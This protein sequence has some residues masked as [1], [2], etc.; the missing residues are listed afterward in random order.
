MNVDDDILMNKQFY[1]K[2]G[3]RKSAAMLRRVNK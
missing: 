3:A 2:M 1:V